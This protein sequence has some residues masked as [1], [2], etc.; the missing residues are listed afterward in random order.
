MI[1]AKI[2]KYIMEK[3]RDLVNWTN[4]PAIH[5]FTY[6]QLKNFLLKEGC[7]SYEFLQLKNPDEMVNK[8]FKNWKKHIL[9]IVQKYPILM[10]CMHV[11][12][13]TVNILAVKK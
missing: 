7:I 5:W 9:K 2:M 12:L 3:R 13:R 10:K 11:Y 4:M 8:G 6:P 1:K